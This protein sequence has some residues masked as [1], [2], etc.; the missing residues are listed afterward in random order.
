MNQGNHL[1][2][3]NSKKNKNK[4]IVFS[5]PKHWNCFTFESRTA[6][7]IFY[8]KFKHHLILLANKNHMSS[9][10]NQQNTDAQ[11]PAR[12]QMKCK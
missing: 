10:Q 12:W 3:I 7:D 8:V 11:V 5:K 6:E 4:N 2:G 9:V 1:G